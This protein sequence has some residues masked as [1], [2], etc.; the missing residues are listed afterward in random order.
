MGNGYFGCL[1][2]LKIKGP[3]FQRDTGKSSINNI[4][5]SVE[6]TKGPIRISRKTA[7]QYLKELK[8]YG[9][10]E[11]VSGKVRRYRLTFAGKICRARWG[12]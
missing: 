8:E 9:L 11:S 12:V 4:S 6:N 10:V 2:D 3:H 5:R 1:K 7:S